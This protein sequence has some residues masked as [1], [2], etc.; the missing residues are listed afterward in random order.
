MLMCV[1]FLSCFSLNDMRIYLLEDDRPHGRPKRGDFRSSEGQKNLQ[2]CEKTLPKLKD[3][4]CMNLP[5]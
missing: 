2:A 3:E 4:I 1:N 5:N